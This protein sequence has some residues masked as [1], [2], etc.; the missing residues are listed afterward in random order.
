M[1]SRNRRKTFIPD[2]YYHA[3]NRGVEK[4]TIFLDDA[5]YAV[6]LHLIKRYLGD[7][8]EKDLKGREYPNYHGAVEVVVFC[9]M[10]NHYHFLLYVHDETVVSRVWQAINGSYVMYFNKKYKRVGP[11]FQDRFK[12]KYVFEES[13]LQHISRYIH[14]NPKQWRAWKFSSLPY[15][16]A[17]RTASWCY[18][19]RLNDLSAKRYL[20]FLE[21]YEDYKAMLDD[22]KARIA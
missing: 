10:P 9:L 17:E 6:Y 20:E 15:Y 3:Y 13:Y 14:L 7:Q 11:L 2:S 12:A 19:D 18:P 5:D 22:V 21:D 16:L 1:P 4:R 8:P